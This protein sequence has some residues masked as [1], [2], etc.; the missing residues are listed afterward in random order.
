MKPHL[1]SVIAAALAVTAGTARVA[2]AGDDAA[3]RNRVACY[4]F[5]IDKIGRGDLQAGTAL[6]KECFS[7]DFSF[8]AFIGRGEPT[9]CPGDFP[10]DM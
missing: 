2:D 5:G 6:W 7:P 10:K 3:V 1:V 8:S 9:R 4:P